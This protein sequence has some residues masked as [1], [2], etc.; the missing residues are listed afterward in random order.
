MISSTVPLLVF[1]SGTVVSVSK[2]F[3]DKN[4]EATA[5]ANQTASEA[6][7]NVHTVYA[8]TNEENVVESF[9][10]QLKIPMQTAIRIKVIASIGIGVSQ[11]FMYSSF[12]LGVWYGGFLLKREDV[13]FGQMLLYENEK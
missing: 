7:Q 6:I 12:A 5:E 9:S 2:G 11:I 13:T 3:A 10:K 8:F 4:R 1:A